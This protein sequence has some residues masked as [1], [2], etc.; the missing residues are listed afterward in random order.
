MN[1]KARASVQL[2]AEAGLEKKWTGSETS[3]C[4]LT[5]L[6][7]GV[8]CLADPVRGS[9]VQKWKASMYGTVTEHGENGC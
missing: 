9:D 2:D 6:S 4:L 3:F 1:T 7:P 5:M 8:L